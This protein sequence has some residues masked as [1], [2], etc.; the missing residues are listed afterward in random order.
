M[1]YDQHLCC[2][3]DEALGSWLSLEYLAKTDQSAWSTNIS[4]YIS[5]AVY[6]VGNTY[7]VYSVAVRGC[8]C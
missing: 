4:S 6:D 2:L 7:I 3:H 1:Q 5:F 8:H